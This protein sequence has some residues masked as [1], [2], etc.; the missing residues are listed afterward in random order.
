MPRGL[1]GDPERAGAC[2]N[3]AKKRRPSGSPKTLA[4]AP[5]D[6]GA[7]RARAAARHQLLGLSCPG[8]RRSGRARSGRAG[9][10]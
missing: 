1:A 3:S 5:N 10:A 8:C 2:S 7:G 9:R 6:R 4:L